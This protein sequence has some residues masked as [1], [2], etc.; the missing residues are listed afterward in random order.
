MSHLDGMEVAEHA[1]QWKFFHRCIS[2]DC[3]IIFKTT[4]PDFN[5]EGDVVC[6][7]QG[8]GD[9][10]HEI[11]STRIHTPEVFRPLIVPHRDDGRAYM[12]ANE[13]TQVNESRT[14]MKAQEDSVEFIREPV[15][16]AELLPR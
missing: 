3:G 15:E 8:E 11:E 4:S 1:K 5:L 6:P 9:E 12:G 10:P 2:K 16:F 14:E 13:G 7:G